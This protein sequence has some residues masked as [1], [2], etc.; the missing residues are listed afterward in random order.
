MKMNIYNYTLETKTHYK[1][2]KL[3]LKKQSIL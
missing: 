3:Q 1:S 2:N